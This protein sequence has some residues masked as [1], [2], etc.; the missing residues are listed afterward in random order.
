MLPG[1]RAQALE[2]DAVEVQD[3]AEAGG[4]GRAARRERARQGGA[5]ASEGRGG[6]LA[7]REWH[8]DAGKGRS[9]LGGSL[10]LGVVALLAD[11]RRGKSVR[12]KTI[13][14][15]SDDGSGSFPVFP[16]SCSVG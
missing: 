11:G 1:A 8:G 12:Q 14:Q 6:G 4:R 15:L 16:G 10:C 2:Q 7:W 5:E 13:I 9:A 3:D